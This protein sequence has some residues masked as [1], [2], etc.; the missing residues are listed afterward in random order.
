V[1]GKRRTPRSPSNTPYTDNRGESIVV[2]GK[3]PSIV[4]ENS[5]SSWDRVSAGYFETL[6]QP[7]LR[8]RDIGRE[9]TAST[10]GVAVIN[11]T[12]A[13]AFF[14]GEDPI[15]RHFGMMSFAMPGPSR[16]SASSE[17]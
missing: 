15:G 7:V 6:G 8:G 9:D 3:D 12:L 17:T 10:R 5:E 11:K 14:K 13:N 2:Q 1:H 16:S 4:G